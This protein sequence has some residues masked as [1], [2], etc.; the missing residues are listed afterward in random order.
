MDGLLDEKCCDGWQI[1][2]WARMVR[3]SIRRQVR[4]AENVRGFSREVV[5]SRGTTKGRIREGEER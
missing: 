2:E 5:I 3:G 4:A 1:C